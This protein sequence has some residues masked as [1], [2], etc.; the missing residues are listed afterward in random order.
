MGKSTTLRLVERELDKAPDRYLVIKFDA[1]MYQD[2]DDACAA[3]MSV[4]SGA[5]EKAAAGSRDGK[6]AVFL[7]DNHRQRQPIEPLRRWLHDVRFE[8][9]PLRRPDNIDTIGKPLA[10]TKVVADQQAGAKTGSA[11]S[12]KQHHC[13]ARPL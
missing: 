9:Q 13:P 10:Q 11:A 12:S 2:F 1:W 8:L 7:L 6:A 4:I 5:L 3:L